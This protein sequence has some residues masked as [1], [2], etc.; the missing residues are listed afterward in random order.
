MY[1]TPM[2]MVISPGN[3]HCLTQEQRATKPVVPIHE[4]ID[5]FGNQIWRLVA[6][7][8]LLNIH[9]NAVAEV[10][11]L[12]DL[13][14]LDLPKTPVENLPDDVLVY[15]LPSRYCPSDLFTTGALQ[16]FGP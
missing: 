3:N 1:P 8:G 16:L 5:S 12:P 13:V 6:A 15:T 10:S 14:R 9:Y 7:I 4:Y 11:A 2:L